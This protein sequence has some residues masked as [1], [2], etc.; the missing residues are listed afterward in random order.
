MSD[1]D[2]NHHHADPPPM[3]NPPE[4]WPLEKRIASHNKWVKEQG[5]FSHISPDAPPEILHQFLSYKC[6]ICSGKP[7]KKLRDF[8]DP[9]LEVPQP[10]GIPDEKV[11]EVLAMYSTLLKKKNFV[12]EG[13]EHQTPRDLLNRLAEALDEEFHEMGEDGTWHITTGDDCPECWR[14]FEREQENFD[15]KARVRNEIA[16]VRSTF[17][18][19]EG[20]FAQADEEIGND[21]DDPREGLGRLPGLDRLMLLLPCVLDRLEEDIDKDL[22]SLPIGG[23]GGAAHQLLD[24][25]GAIKQAIQTVLTWYIHNDVDQALELVNTALEGARKYT[26]KEE[27]GFRGRFLHDLARIAPD[28]QIMRGMLEDFQEN[29]RRRPK[30]PE[31]NEL[32][33]TERW[34]KYYRE[35]ARL[36]EPM[37]AVVDAEGLSEQSLEKGM[38]LMIEESKRLDHHKEEFVERYRLMK[39]RDTVFDPERP[40]LFL[41]LTEIPEVED[42][43]DDD[44]YEVRSIDLRYEEDDR[45]SPWASSLPELKAWNK[46]TMEPTLEDEEDPTRPDFLKDP[47]Y[48]MLDPFINNLFSCLKEEYF[49][50]IQDSG[51]EAYPMRSPLDHYLILVALKAQARISSCGVWVDSA[52]H[53]APRHGAY[54]FAMDCLERIAEAVE[55]FAPESLQHLATQARHIKRRIKNL[56]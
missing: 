39:N 21:P 6:P 48:R 34:L 23:D 46:R 35:Q 13:C 7:A 51:E 53:P 50:T 44:D 14:K 43:G 4:D 56:I 26:V 42:D 28:F 1:I 47:V 31:D 12:L 27:P 32:C 55:R 29:R 18:K 9:P 25:L 54:M 5:G 11:E 10:D 36:E 8:F 30:H 38:K 52:G 22:F 41:D 3:Q 2:K 40:E 33:S 16:A 45:P 37:F 15:W 49:E 24:G 17:D 20:F 19:L